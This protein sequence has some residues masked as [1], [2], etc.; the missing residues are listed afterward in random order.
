MMRYISASIL[1]HVLFVAGMVW[2]GI[3]F[4]VTKK[5]L[6]SATVVHIV[7]RAGAPAKGTPAG[8]A[9][10]VVPEPRKA[11][12]T[13]A[14]EKS[15]AKKPAPAPAAAKVESKGDERSLSGAA[16]TMYVGGDFTYDWY[17][18]LI[19]SKIEQSFRP[20]PGRRKSL[21]AV[22][23]FRISKAG[24]IVALQRRQSS[25][26]FLFDQAAERAVR[27]AGRFPPLPANFDAT[28]LGINFE[29]VSNPSP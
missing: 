3:R 27:A 26:D 15:G 25:G 14:K 4:G 8:A 11:L 13:P 18:T 16:G 22:L 17:L 2:G 20:P 1:L 12:V 29:F 21:M 7:R 5:P 19:Q 9:K 10:A 28:E 24:E 23:E 6:P